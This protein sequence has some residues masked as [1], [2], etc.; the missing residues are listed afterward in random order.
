M[1]RVLE[2][3]SDRVTPGQRLVLLALGW[4]ARDD[5]SNA[6]P[7]VSTLCQKTSLSR[8]GVQR[9]LSGLTERGML[10][11]EA[12]APRRSV[13]YGINLAAFDCATSAQSEPL[14]CATSA[15]STPSVLDDCA[16][17]APHRAV[18]AQNCA[19]SAPHRATSA[20]DPSFNRS[21]TV[22]EIR[23]GADARSI[24]AEEAED[25]TE[26]KTEE[27]PRRDAL[28]SDIPFR[29]YASIA[30]RAITESL[31]E[32]RSDDLENID[33]R[34]Q[35]L[36]AEQGKPCDLDITRRAVDAAWV[37]REKEKQRFLKT[38]RRTG[39]RRM[40]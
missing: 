35:R 23:T 17:S 10:R 2:L 5:G 12:A 38:F 11:V 20:P 34:F 33:A 26:E 25:K 1:A 13:R 4:H 6:W 37:S 28:I 24:G 18:S 16:T 19:T 31:R 36:C 8:R 22:L 32:D 40:G 21:L 39:A 9:I 30:T 15:Q 29:V 27:P 3:A 7:A 14:D